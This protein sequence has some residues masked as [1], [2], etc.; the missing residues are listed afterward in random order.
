MKLKIEIKLDNAAFEQETTSL[1]SGYEVSRIL[2]RLSNDVRHDSLK[3]GDTYSL[4]DV[5]GNHAGKAS[6]KR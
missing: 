2:D 5:N 6:V 3:V 4:H 1:R